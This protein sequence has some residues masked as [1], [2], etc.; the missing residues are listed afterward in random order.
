MS[1]N[2]VKRNPKK[3]TT[4]NELG[5][6]F[7][8]N[9]REYNKWGKSWQGTYPSPKLTFASGNYPAAIFKHNANR[10]K[11]YG[12]SIEENNKKKKKRKT[13]KRLARINNNNNNRNKSNK[14]NNNKNNKKKN[15]IKKFQETKMDGGK[16][17][18]RRKVPLSILFGTKLS[19]SE[20]LKRWKALKKR[21]S[22]K[23]HK[24]HKKR[25]KSHKKRKSRRKQSGGSSCL[26]CIGNRKSEIR[27]LIEPEMQRIKLLSIERE[28]LP[29]GPGRRLNK[30]KRIKNIKQIIKKIADFIKMGQCGEEGPRGPGE[31]GPRGLGAC[32]GDRG[33]LELFDKEIAKNDKQVEKSYATKG[34]REIGFLRLFLRW[35]KCKDGCPG[36]KLFVSSV[37]DTM[38]KDGVD[39]RVVARA[40]VVGTPF[41]PLD[42]A[43][44]QVGT[45]Y[46]KENHL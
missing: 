2:N 6:M 43:L 32:L 34:V 12:E 15:A 38:E 24:S 5:S 26:V 13:K 46:N 41:G 10:R 14:K 44:D 4:M 7:H 37:V 31:E 42:I 23:K 45:T 30:A 39:A 28:L 22:H 8:S 21:K 11:F 1:K 20:R 9:K 3:N 40:K 25:C 19:K 17:K 36:D 18:S 27:S 35:L 29:R 33:I 16:R